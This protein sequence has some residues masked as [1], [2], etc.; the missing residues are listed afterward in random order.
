MLADKD[1]NFGHEILG[2]L[3]GAPVAAALDSS[4][5]PVGV[6]FADHVLRDAGQEAAV[7]IER[8][9]G[10]GARAVLLQQRAVVLAVLVECAVDVK[11]G[12]HG[13][14]LRKRHGVV[15]EIS[16]GDGVGVAREAIVKVLNVDSLTAFDERLRQINLLR[17]ISGKFEK[18]WKVRLTQWNVKCQMPGDPAKSSYVFVP[19][20]GHS[21]HVLYV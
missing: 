18:Y 16:G 10:H 11:A 1:K 9:R 8:L 6:H 21:P 12:A 13:T 4:R 19:G 17:A 14:G 2:I 15:I 5:S 20:R 3:L 7:A